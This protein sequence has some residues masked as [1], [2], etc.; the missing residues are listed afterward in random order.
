MRVPMITLV[1]ALTM[2]G[3]LKSDITRT[4]TTYPPRPEGCEVD[5]V[6]DGPP[7]Y[8][9][10][11]VAEAEVQC[12]SE[13]QGREG[14]IDKLKAMACELGA[15]AAYEFHEGEGDGYVSISAS[16][17]RKTEP[18]SAAAPAPAP[19]DAPEAGPAEGSEASEAAPADP[20]AP[21]TE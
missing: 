7:E 6:P 15:H 10:E 12:H 16:F 5:I 2:F 18:E 13:S 4:G 14:C 17:A 19:E 8:E 9:F 11:K 21:P 3:C 20:V 1:A